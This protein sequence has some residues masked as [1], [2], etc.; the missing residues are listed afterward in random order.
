MKDGLGS[1]KGGKDDGVPDLERESLG[2]GAVVAEDASEGLGKGKIDDEL[3]AARC[4][5]QAATRAYRRLLGQI[6]YSEEDLSLE[7]M[8]ALRQRGGQERRER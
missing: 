8:M 7:T 5:L 4:E 1:S 2:R 3:G 6:E